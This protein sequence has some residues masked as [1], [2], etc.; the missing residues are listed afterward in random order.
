M[1]SLAYCPFCASTGK[2]PT[3]PKDL[4]ILVVFVKSAVRKLLS[5]VLS[6]LSEEKLNQTVAYWSKLLPGEQNRTMHRAAVVM[7]LMATMDLVRDSLLV[8]HIAETLLSLLVAE[9]GRDMFR[10]AAMELLASGLSK[11]QDHVHV[12]SLFRLV[13]SWAFALSPL[14]NMGGPADSAEFNY[15]I[16]AESFA[17]ILQWDAVHGGGR[18]IAQWCKDLLQS[19]LLDRIISMELLHRM[20]S[21]KQHAGLLVLTPYLGMIVETI[22]KL[23]DPSHAEDRERLR[24]TM[25]PLLHALVTTVFRDVCVFDQTTQYLAV[26][27]SPKLIIVYDLKS[28]TVL[29]EHPTTA[30]MNSFVKI[31][32]KGQT[33]GAL[34]LSTD[35]ACQLSVFYLGNSHGFLFFRSK[36]AAPVHSPPSIAVSQ[37]FEECS[38]QFANSHLQLCCGPETLIK[39]KHV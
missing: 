7:G 20:L 11:W 38:L 17:A 37:T 30:E 22:V 36:P 5:D 16:V 14:R 3:V 33:L 35:G 19:A 27:S 25:I 2:I 12:G 18:V 21:K 4:L 26:I 1:C 39:L 10:M 9:E 15:S 6:S 31:A 34:S 8:K 32:L 13:L 24:P 29:S 28:A 23:L